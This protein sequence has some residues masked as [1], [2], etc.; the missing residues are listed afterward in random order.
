MRVAFDAHVVGEGE[1]GN[2]TYAVNLLRALVNDPG[3][4]FYQVLTP[5]PDR[6]RAI[7][8]LPPSAT[9]VRVRPS[10]SVLRIPV[11][12]PNAVRQ[13]RSELLHVS[14]VA[15]PVIGC[16]TVV[17]I[18]DLSYLAYPRSLSPRARLML[19][20]LVPRSV[21]RAARVIAVSQFTRDD[22]VR[23]YGIAE[24]KISVIHEAAGPAFRVLDDAGSRQLPAGVTE[25]FVLAVGNLEPR[26]NLERLVEAFAAAAREPG[27]T[28]KLVLVGKDK[29]Q[30]ASLARLV[31]QYGVRDRVVF[32]GFVTEAELVLLYNRAALFI[33]PSLYEGFGLPPLEA[34]A[35]GCPV[36]ASNVTAMPEVLG[37][38]ALLVN[39]TSTHAMA[40]AMRE[41]LRRDA[42]ARDLRSRGLR[43]VARYSWARAAEQTREVY[44][45]AVAAAGAGR[46]A[47]S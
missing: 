20:V 11:G 46:T 37:E 45:N 31:D 1:S 4:N 13:H 27:V 32:T 43:Q 5:H 42:L 47:A 12:I 40:E 18:H 14:Y 6:L 15:P 38:A 10:V 33:Y 17:T 30:A 35:C 41:L 8:E 22:V 23:R 19:T 7:I 28:V 36:V 9:V 44:R 21:R 16:P 26:K 3:G 39:P 34:M 25:P 29:R 24:E 2:E